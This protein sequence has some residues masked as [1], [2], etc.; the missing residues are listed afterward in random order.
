MTDVLHCSFCGKSQHEVEQLQDQDLSFVTN[1]CRRPARESSRR[2]EA[3][4]IQPPDE[5]VQLSWNKSSSYAPMWPDCM[6]VW[7]GLRSG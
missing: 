3:V 7:P 1:V 5:P 6:T 2:K 4:P